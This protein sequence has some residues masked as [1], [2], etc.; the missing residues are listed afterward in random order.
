[1]S[2]QQPVPDRRPDVWAAGDAYEPYVGRW[3]RLVAREFLAWLALGPDL[4]WLDVGCGTGALTQT[5]LAQANPREVIGIDPSEGFIAY[6]RDR[7]RDPRAAFK[8]ADVRGLAAEAGGF[9]AAVAGLVLN[10]IPEPAAA[11][12]AMARAVRPGGTVACYVWD[13]AEG[14]QLM[15]VFWD[16]VVALDPGAR[17]LDEGRRFPLCRPEPLRALF[18]E[19]GLQRTQV[20]A[21]DVPTV[22]ESFDDYWSPFLG[23]QGPAPT[24]AM[25][26]PEVRRVALR[27][28]LRASL[29][30][31][32]DGSIPLTARAWA[33]RGTRG[34]AS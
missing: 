29:P 31:A 22:F 30:V 7:T 32:A 25:S 34:D 12:T 26:L 3:S 6:A 28:R 15:R 8:T 4:R 9:D 23:G 5:I 13:Y 19:A 18:D 24:Y 20:R 1:M 14:M 11:L 2:M 10:F 33:V 27:E 16:A 17:E 21:I